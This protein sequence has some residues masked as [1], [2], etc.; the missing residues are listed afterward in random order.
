M[1]AGGSGG[2]SAAA[3]VGLLRACWHAVL[4]QPPGAGKRPGQALAAFA[5]LRAGISSRALG[6]RAGLPAAGGGL[7]G[8]QPVGLGAG[9][10]DVGVVGD[11]VHD[12]GNEAWVGEHGAP[13]AERQVGGDR[14]GGSL[15]A[16]GDDLEE[17]LGAAGVDLDVAELVEQR[18]S[19][20]P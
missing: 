2:A 15:F 11:A 16:F 10:E 12:R 19:R 9:F 3:P 18:R 5:H 6:V 20:R 14:D 7:A 1:G 4:L 17:Q 8:A 13:F